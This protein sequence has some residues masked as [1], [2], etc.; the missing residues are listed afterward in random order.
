MGAT[1]ISDDHGYRHEAL[2]YAGEAAFMD[3]T[4]AFVREAVARGE[5]IL[6]VL[7]APKIAALRGALG[8]DG[9]HVLFADMA[10]VGENP[11]RIIPAWEDF[12]E[13]N[14]A[15][16]RR[17]WGIGEPI[18]AGRGAA[19]LVECQ[20]HEA[21][22]NVVFSDPDFSLLCPYDVRALDPATIAEARRTHPYVRECGV[23]A[24]ASAS[25][26]GADA[27]AGPF[28]APLPAPPPEMAPPL[29]F[30]RETLREVRRL[31]R[32]HGAAARLPD[33]RV[34]DLVLAVDEVATN[35]V[36]HGGGGG[37]LRV[38]Q[39]PRA[40]VC[41]LRDAGRIEDPLAG[42]RPPAADATSGY[43]LWIANQ[44]CELVQVRTYPSGSVIRLHMRLEERT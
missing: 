31:V 32:A 40:L 28:D 18:W 23:I 44:L 22:L 34:S 36:R 30:G 11:A 3:G 26:P 21:L 2:L 8:P 20:R 17:L 41:E 1:A 29:A 37:E 14:A 9:G 25:F 10:E 15:P 4:L 39:E 43:G 19:E 13:R 16:G 24:G 35:S 12:V 27:F 7:G 5:P 6:V 38:W 33:V 42:R